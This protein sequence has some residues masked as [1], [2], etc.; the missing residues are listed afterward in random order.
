MTALLQAELLKLR[1]TRTFI[2]FAGLA[3]GTSLLIAGLVC[4]LTEP[5][6]DSVLTDVFTADTSSLF[7]IILAVVGI[8]GDGATARSPAPCWPLRIAFGSWPPRRSRSPWS[9]S[10]VAGHLALRGRRRLHDPDCA[11]PP[12]AR[13]RR[14]RGQ[15]GH[16]A[17]VAMLLGAF[18]VGVGALVRTRWS[19]SSGS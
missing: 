18:G 6:Q 15:I 7:I 17:S 11:R 10:A 5:T 4:L 12:D 1:T 19:R 13:A 2:A 9:G 16:N 14:A 8:S 3:V